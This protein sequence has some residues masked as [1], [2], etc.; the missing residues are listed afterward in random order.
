VK[1]GPTSRT[2]PRRDPERSTFV[3]VTTTHAA[4]SRFM[5]RSSGHEGKS[6][7]VTARNETAGGLPQDLRRSRWV[8]APLRRED[9][10]VTENGA[11]FY[12]PPPRP[13][14][15]G[16]FRSASRTFGTSS[17]RRVRRGRT[18]GTCA[19]FV[20]SF[21]TNFEV[22]SRFRRRFASSRRLRH[23]GEDAERSALAY[24]EIIRNEGRLSPGAAAKE[25]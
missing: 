12:D 8:R 9:L 22:E 24:A 14:P 20:W 2:G 6:A 19:H 18:A 1:S 21:S 23:A 7:S 3:G 25:S 10:Y 5:R 4:W 16:G 13:V 15:S 11:A 17:S